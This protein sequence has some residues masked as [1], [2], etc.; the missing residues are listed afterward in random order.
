MILGDAAMSGGARRILAIVPSAYCFGLQNVTLAFFERLPPPAKA[1]FLTTRWSDG[2][3]ARRLNELGIENSATWLGMFS[4]RFD[5]ENLRMTM[6]CLWRLP[7]AYA[8]FLRVYRQFKPTTLYFANH[9]ELI[10]LWP[11]LVC[12]RRKV[13]CHM[14]DPPPPCRFQRLSFA[15]WRL[16]VH[17]FLCISDSVR[18]RLSLLGP[19]S[20]KDIVIHNGVV[21]RELELPRT[22]RA[23]FTE[24]FGWSEDSVIFGIT[25][26]VNPDKGHEDFVAAAE[27]VSAQLPH[28]RFVIGG[29]Q[30]NEFAQ[31]LQDRITGA[32]LSQIIRFSRWT[33]QP[34]EFYE[35]I[36]VLV[37]ASRSDE[38]FGLVVAEAGERGLPVI[39]T[40]SGGA[41][42]IVLDKVTGLLIDKGDLTAMVSAMLRLA[43]ARLRG[44][45]GSSAR[46]RV[47]EHF[48]LDTQVFE[49]VTALE[50]GGVP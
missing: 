28:A 50:V 42:E 19:L 15:I 2:E 12:L 3:F 40:R 32:G 6:E 14:H 33:D 49:F 47:A 24:E 1:Y 45:L 20:R 17:R 22:R 8:A 18:S 13:V 43:D 29:R 46:A 23:R 30:I 39:A 4:R 44:R 10:L 34:Q 9:H 11:V 36:D 37:L 31:S 16:P 38:G 25:G 41:V 26:Q 5:R 35:A 7:L 27:Q 48:N 21:V